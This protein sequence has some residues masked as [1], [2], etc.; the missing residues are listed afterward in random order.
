[1]NEV[2]GQGPSLQAEMYAV[3]K[4]NETQAVGLDKIL[5]STK[6]PEQSQ[7]MQSPSAQVTG[8]GQNLDTKA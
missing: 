2:T 4:A 5:E 1:M 7:S 6:V 3:R 8:V